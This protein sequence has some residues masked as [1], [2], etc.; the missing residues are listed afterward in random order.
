MA[1]RI[2]KTHNAIIV[3]YR[4]FPAGWSIV[5]Y[6][7]RFVRFELGKHTGTRHPYSGYTNVYHRWRAM[8]K[9]RN[10]IITNLVEAGI[11]IFKDLVDGSCMSKEDV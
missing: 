1:R 6:K 5:K 7:D 2:P 10:L 11:T 9:T 8:Y 3:S 4:R